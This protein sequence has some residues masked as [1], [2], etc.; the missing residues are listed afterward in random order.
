MDGISSHSYMHIYI[1]IYKCM[2]MLYI[3][4]TCVFVYTHINTTRSKTVRINTI[5]MYVNINK[6]RSTQLCLLLRSCVF[7]LVMMLLVVSKLCLVVKVRTCVEIVSLVCLISPCA[8]SVRFY[9]SWRRAFLCRSL[10]GV[11]H[12]LFL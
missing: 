3:Y 1:Y 6:F 2:Y 8:C 12:S 10:L 4:I 7:C 9:V 11:W 5:C